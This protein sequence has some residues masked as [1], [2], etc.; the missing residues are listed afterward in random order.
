MQ[1]QEAVKV[2]GNGITEVSFANNK[3]MA[4]LCG[5]CAIESRDMA[6]SS[7]EA[8]KTIA[9]KLNIGVVYKSS[10]DK[11]NRSSINSPRGVGIDAGLKIL[12]EVKDTFKMPIVT[13]IH[14]A[15][16]CDQVAEVADIL[17]IP[18]FLCRQ[19]DLIVAAANT[20]RV[21]N[22]K[23]GQF[24]APEDAK[25]IVS[26]ILETNS[27]NIM[28]TERG[29]SFG[30]NTLVS[31]MRG[32]QIMAKNGY[33][34]IFDATH[35]VQM[36]GGQGTTSGGKREFVEVLAR[37]AL[38]TGIAGVFLEAHPDPKNAFSDG[39]N[40]V[41]LDKLEGLLATLKRFDEIA[42]SSEYQI[43]I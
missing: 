21:V 11:A 6:M 20:G 40:Q 26:K 14:E 38:S 5:P 22:V 34:V 12:Q 19:T 25:N 13:D 37:A 41:P 17:Q 24:L 28:L 15:H 39:P 36:P 2:G 31:D 9:D 7:A 8:I 23:K 32:L 27:R 10:F 4:I 33:P 3:P 30:Y 35:S 42:K 1:N 18:A 43:E 29:T 16:Q